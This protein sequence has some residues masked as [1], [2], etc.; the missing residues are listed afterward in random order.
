MV[1]DL[2]SIEFFYYKVIVVVN[3]YR[4]RKFYNENYLILVFLVRTIVGVDDPIKAALQN[5]SLGW[6]N[7]VHYQEVPNLFKLIT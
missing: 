4:Q 2:Y 1:K 7:T 6:E 3:I 5:S